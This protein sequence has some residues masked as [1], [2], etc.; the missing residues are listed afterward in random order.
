MSRSYK[1]TPIVKDGGK[2]SKKNKQLANRKVRRII[3]RNI[4]IILK[5]NDHKKVVETW[6][7]NDYVTRFTEKEAIEVYYRTISSNNYYDR[8]FKEEYPTLEDWLKKYRKDYL[9]K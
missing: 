4:D 1:H 5:G 7:I 3:N 9:Y 2:S 8:W 6:D